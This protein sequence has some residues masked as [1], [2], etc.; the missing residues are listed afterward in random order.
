MSS[1]ED[2]VFNILPIVHL[3]EAAFTTLISAPSDLCIL[4]HHPT[5]HSSFHHRRLIRGIQVETLKLFLR[6]KLNTSVPGLDTDRCKGTAIGFRCRGLEAIRYEELQ[7]R[8]VGAYSV[9]TFSFSNHFIDALSTLLLVLRLS[10]RPLPLFRLQNS[11]TQIDKLPQPT[12][13]S[14]Y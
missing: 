7:N 3:T 14:R 5:L 1:I 11:H 13:I 6:H 10:L 12:P 4:L 8:S 9:S 2:T